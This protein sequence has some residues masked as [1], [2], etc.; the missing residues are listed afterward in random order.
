MNHQTLR[1]IVLALILV[2]SPHVFSQSSPEAESR[3]NNGLAHLRDGQTVLALEE[4]RWAI[5]QD[6]KNPYFYKGLGLALAQQN[7][8]KEAIDAYRKALELNPY[9]VDVRNDLGASLILAGQR[10]AGKKEFR[11]A[12]EDPTNPTPETSARNLGQAFFEEKNYPEA[13]NWFDTSL[14]RNK[15]YA[16][17]YLGLA[18]TLNVMGRSEEA[19]QKLEAGVANLANDIDLTLA[20]GVAYYRA[21]RFTEARVRLEKVAAKDPAGASGRK[22]VDLLKNL[23]K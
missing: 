18:D 13:L 7:K 1:P 12:F 22:A 4:F 2:G 9:Y 11:T 21:G 20:L 14:S 5:K 19:I 17:A 23:P 16:D 8:Q 6:P 10:D 3:F 15:D